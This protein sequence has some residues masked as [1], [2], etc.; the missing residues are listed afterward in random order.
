MVS[1]LSKPIAAKSQDKLRTLKGPRELAAR[2]L[3]RLHG[4]P[5]DKQLLGK[6][7]WMDYIKD[8]DVVLDAAINWKS[9]Q[10]HND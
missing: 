1:R 10:P 4:V 8:V 7:M 6:P 9:R 3:C 2:A 5:E